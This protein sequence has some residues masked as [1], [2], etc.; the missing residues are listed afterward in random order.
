MSNE[1]YEAKDREDMACR[2]HAA[3]D[4]LDAQNVPISSKDVV[5]YSRLVDHRQQDAKEMAEL[6][7][8]RKWGLPLSPP[9][10]VLAV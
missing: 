8:W 3:I 6:L 2:L 1:Q 9:P 10:E 4:I 7:L 5:E